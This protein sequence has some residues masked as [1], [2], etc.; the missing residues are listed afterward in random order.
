MENKEKEIDVIELIKVVWS[1][2]KLLI[3]WGVIGAVAGLIIAFS[4]PKQY[5]TVVKIAPE[6]G[7]KTTTGSNSLGALAEL[8]GFS[9]VRTNDGISEKIYPE[10]IGSTPFILEF[11]DIMVDVKGDQITF[12]DYMTKEQKAPW[13]SYVMQLPLKA[14]GAVVGLFSDEKED[15][16]EELSIFKPTPRQK[17][18]VSAVKNRIL[19]DVDKKMGFITLTTTMQDPLIAAVISDSVLSNLQKYM[20]EYRTAKNRQDLD[21]NI[22]RLE[23]VK[24]KYYFADSL[25]AASLD[26]NHGLISQSAKM[27]VERLLG[28]RT[29]AF[30]VYQQLA[31]QVEM[32]KVKLQEST[33]IATVIEPASVAIRAS[34]PKKSLI[35]IAFTFL[36]AFGAAMVVV[37]K[38]I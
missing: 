17:S 6:G 3:R 24:N 2:K 8:G 4:I 12:Y 21:V 38:K 30:S 25:Y 34:S 15:V 37:V 26:R 29:L 16:V 1:R 32:N 28:E 22:Q 11:A 7:N 5:E 27:K 18:Y 19:V 35:L 36:G 23:D 20:L 10:I 14:I 31:A 33:P 9:S 13:W